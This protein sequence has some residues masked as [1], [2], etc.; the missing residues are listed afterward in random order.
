VISLLTLLIA[1]GPESNVDQTGDES[2]VPSTADPVELPELWVEYPERGS[3]DTS[4]SGTVQGQVAP[5]SA[6]ISTVLINGES[7][8]IGSDGSFSKDVNWTQGIQIIG[9]RTEDEDG[10]RAVDGR[11]IQAGP[12]HGPGDWIPG[13]LRIEI[14]T[15]ILDDD[16]PEIDDIAALLEA[17]LEDESIT[18]M[19]LGTP[20]ESS[21]FVI[22]PT[23][24]EFASADVDLVPGEG[25]ITAEISLNEVILDFDIAGTGV[26]GWVSTSGQAWVDRA[27]VGTEV[28]VSSSGGSIRVQPVWIESDLIGYGLTVDYFP[29]SLED[30]LADWTEGLLEDTVEDIGG[31]V[32]EDVLATALDAFTIEM[33]LGDDLEMEADLSSIEVVPDAVRF[34]VD[35]RVSAL[36]PIDIPSNAGSL[37]TA[38]DPPSWPISNGARLGVAVDDDFLNQ[39]SFAFWH[40]GQLH[41][42]SFPG[43]AVGGMAG[44]ALPPP[45]GPADNVILS[46]GLPPV[47][48]QPRDSAFDADI[49]VGEWR[50]LFE[51]TDGEQ[52]EFSV[53]LRAALNATLSGGSTLEVQLDDRPAQIDLEIGV[54][55]APEAID[56]GDLAALV[57]LMIPPLIG[58]TAD[59]VPV[60]PIPT[61]PMGQLMDISAASDLEIGMTDPE[62][63]FTSAGWLLLRADLEIH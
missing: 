63:E 29:D 50:I 2:V 49:S 10:E 56:P 44:T 57:R 26:F 45:L 47:A 8:Q 36:T 20:L 43:I 13:A 12:V 52:L 31:T 3:F 4:G 46:L 16:T 53:N 58:N 7:T 24:L 25:T 5:G 54:L 30:N 14:D 62:M 21:G 55:Q 19:L 11:A 37:S 33:D 27:E 18:D 17:A 39:L 42:V 6:P 34:I 60:I 59:L 23:D 38:G 9:V 1:C 32:I 61:I 35:T 51:R 28:S 22:T 48:T 15:V 41:D 40:T